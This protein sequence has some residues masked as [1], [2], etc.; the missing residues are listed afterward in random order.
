VSLFVRFLF[1]SSLYTATFTFY[2]SSE[3]V[4]AVMKVVVVG[5]IYVL[6]SF[7]E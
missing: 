1:F 5:H 4:T 2:A 3:A 7:L 6:L